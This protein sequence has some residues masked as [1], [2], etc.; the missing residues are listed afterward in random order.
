MKEQLVCKAKKNVC[1][2]CSN[3]ANRSNQCHLQALQGVVFKDVLPGYTTDIQTESRFVLLD[4]NPKL[5]VS[6]W[7]GVLP[8]RQ[9]EERVLF[10]LKK[11]G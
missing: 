10:L 1:L 11:N 7:M 6:G 3:I 8:E 9:K 2:N 4:S 5:T